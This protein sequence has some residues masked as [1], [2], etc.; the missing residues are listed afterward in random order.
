MSKR[1]ASGTPQ[2]PMSDKAEFSK[3]MLST[4][5]QKH[6][7]FFLNGQSDLLEVLDILENQLI[8]YCKSV[9]RIEE[10]NLYYQ[11]EESSGED[12]D[13]MEKV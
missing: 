7:D 1:N 2:Q 8:S 13:D 5:V 3:K 6:I 4:A 11:F 12:D 10:I 9:G